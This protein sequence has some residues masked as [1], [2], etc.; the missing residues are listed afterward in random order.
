[1]L[2]LLGSANFD[3]IT[4]NLLGLLHLAIGIGENSEMM[5][6]FRW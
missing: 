2:A 3:D 4:Y 1:M 5:Q 6:G